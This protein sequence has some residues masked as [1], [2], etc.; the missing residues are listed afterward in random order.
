[1]DTEGWAVSVPTGYRVGDWR[2]TRPIA[3]GSW[4]SVYEARP[5]SGDA[6]PAALKFLP[7]GTVTRR[8]LRHLRDMTQREIRLHHTL[9]HPRIVQVSETLV[10]EDAGDPELDGACVLVMELAE[11][12]LADLLR[13]GAPG[14]PVPGAPRLITEIC[15]GLAHLHAEGW[16]HGDLK[17]S[18]V[19]MMADGS[20]RLADFGLATE[21]DGTHGYL[22]PA[23]SIDHVPP[24]RWSEPLTERGYAVRTSADI[25]ALGVTACQLLT[26]HLPFSAPTARARYVAAAE[27]AAGERPL[28]LPSSLP[29]AWRSWIGDCLSPRPRSR[30]E[31]A[32]QLQRARVLAGTVRAP[33]RTRTRAVSGMA[34]A[35]LLT[36]ACGSG[37]TAVDHRPD[38]YARWLR[39][40]SDI[41]REYRGL[42][43]QA[44]TSCGEPGLTPALVAAILK[45]ESGFNPDLSDPA[46]DEY[47]LA[48]WTP[49]VMRFY[50]PVDR[51]DEI[52]T[53]P[54]PPED[55]I[56]AVGRYL[57]VRLPLLAGVPGD[58]G[59]LGAAA[60]RS[61]D[62]VIRQGNGVPARFQPYVD[63]VRR[64][65]ADYQP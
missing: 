38:P 45:A 32:R 34:A 59:L 60:F 15:E 6:A 55:S 47:G 43:V 37:S 18:N 21:I 54:L 4:A 1:M 56:P 52:P 11:G 9:R 29:D 28:A 61:S 42:I 64:F 33:G 26:G 3:S 40:D 12:S 41:P 19:L 63:R 58:Q 50:L 27:Y 13:A 22:P 46:K 51:R 2:V 57:C 30:P 49:S 53:P 5:V 20:I 35:A 25:W 10:V 65:R 16:M 44:G 23:G 24:E 31:A 8:Q 7:T 48:R 39:T 62:D 14:T 17:P 36:L